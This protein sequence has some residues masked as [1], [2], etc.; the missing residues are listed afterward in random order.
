MERWPLNFVIRLIAA[1]LIGVTSLSAATA[2][3]RTSV[4]QDIVICSGGALVTIT[5]GPDGEPVKRL[6]ICPDYALSLFAAHLDTLELPELLLVEVPLFVVRMRCGACA[7]LS[8]EPQARG[9]PVL[10]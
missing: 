10:V 3:G 6:D 9:P 2:H 1:L 8:V 4:G 7:G 5:V